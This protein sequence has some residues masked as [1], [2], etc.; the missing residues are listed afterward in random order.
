LSKADD[1]LGKGIILAEKGH[2]T[3]FQKIACE[4]LA[5]LAGKKGDFKKAYN[6]LLQATILHD[7]IFS[8][9]LK[10]RI[11][12][13]SH[14]YEL[15]R[16]EVSNKLLVKENEIKEQ[17]IFKQRLM[18][19]GSII[20]ILLII[21]LMLVILKSRKK[22]NA[23]IKKLDEQNSELQNLNQTKDKFFSIVAHDLRSPFGALMGL[24]NELDESYEEYDEDSRRNMI[25]SLRKSSLNTYNLLVNLLDW[26]RSQ[27][28]R[29]ENRAENV[30]FTE[31]VEDVFQ[32]LQTR[33]SMKS[34]TLRNDTD[35]GTR[36]FADPQIMRSLLINLVNNGIKFTPKSGQI[37]VY[38]IP[39]GK[40]V[41]VYV[42]DSGTGIPE[43]EIPNLFR[44]DASYQ[45]SGTDKEPGTG[46][47][48]IMCKEYV[49]ILGGDI[50]VESIVGKGTTFCF[51]V[52][53]SEN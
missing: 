31:I 51:S 5:S 20:V 26:S 32:T 29:I 24:L 22:Q 11:M 4:S 28:E 23:L 46:L 52:P 16:V 6:Y 18:F 35:E 50:S 34:H 17:V 37:R 30:N 40:F 12:E 8:Q 25:R 27:R 41:K 44:I 1:L 7:S 43:Q 2:F 49:S 10:D 21:I 45:R 36:I 47:G 3:E 38:A 13:V 33:A 14:Q 53:K 39:D 19:A 42:E 9:D 15:E 48:L